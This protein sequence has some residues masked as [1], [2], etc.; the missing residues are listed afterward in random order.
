MRVARTE[1][2][3]AYRRAD[4]D[5]WQQ[6]DFVLGQKIQLSH[7]H[8]KKDICDKLQGDYPAEFVFDGWHPQC[9]CFVTPRLR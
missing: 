1:T 7:S 6:M 3:L 5:P 9:F 4:H 2:N 8:P